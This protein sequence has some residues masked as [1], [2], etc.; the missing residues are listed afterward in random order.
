MQTSLSRW[1]YSTLTRTLIKLTTAAL[2]CLSSASAF[3]ENPTPPGDLAYKVYSST[4]AEI[5]WD[6]AT[7][8]D[9]YVIGYEVQVAGCAEL[10]LR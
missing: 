1:R 8:S 10:L 9:G 3:A 4:A 5:F 6:R 2:L 7:D